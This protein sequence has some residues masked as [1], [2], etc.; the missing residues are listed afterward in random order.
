MHIEGYLK[1]EGIIS[2]ETTSMQPG[3]GGVLASACASRAHERVCSTVLAAL[4]VAAVRAC[5]RGL[6]PKE[7]VLLLQGGGTTCGN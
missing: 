7:P 6:P 3:M 1:V 2:Q 5:R 4:P